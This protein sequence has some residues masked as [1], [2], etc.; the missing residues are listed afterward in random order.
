MAAGL[1]LNANEQGHCSPGRGGQAPLFVIEEILR[2]KSFSCPAPV[3]GQRRLEVVL[4]LSGT[5]LFVAFL[6]AAGLCPKG[7]GLPVL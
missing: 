2:K 1:F 7:K 5:L 3:A 6:L 4:L